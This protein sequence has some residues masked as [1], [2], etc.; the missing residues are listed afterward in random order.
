MATCRDC[1]HYD[2][3]T[4]WIP[5]KELLEAIKP[6]G[7]NKFKNKA[8]FEEVVRCRDCV[9]RVPFDEEQFNELILDYITT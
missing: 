8:D 3:C 4:D 1:V 9:N 7:C 2:A 6:E 5:P